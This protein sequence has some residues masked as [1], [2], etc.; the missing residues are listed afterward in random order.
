MN[1]GRRRSVRLVQGSSENADIG[2]VPHLRGRRWD[3][4]LW[5]GVAGAIAILTAIAVNEWQAAS[6][7]RSA[8]AWERHT[9]EVLRSTGSLETAVT[10]AVASERGYLLT[11]DARYESRFQGERTA[12]ADAERR[13]VALTADNRE[14]QQSLRSLHGLL[15]DYFGALGTDMAL[16][17]RGAASVH[18]YAI[19][20][21]RL[22]A[23]LQ[24]LA[25]SRA[26][27]RDLLDMRNARNNAASKRIETSGNLLL[28]LGA[29]LLV[30]A[31]AQARA[32]L[33]AVRA[34][35]A[36]MA[37]LRRTSTTDELTDLAN[38]RHFFARLGEE[39]ARAARQGAPLAVA[40]LDV[41]HFKQVNDSHGHA[42]GDAVLRE[43]ADR[44]RKVTR[45]GELVGR[46]GGE[47]FAILLPGA[48]ADQ[49]WRLCD[50][51]REAQSDAPIPLPSGE[52]IRS[53]L[54][55]GVAVAVS[56]E[57]IERLM[58]RADRALYQ[59]KRQGR[60]RDRLAA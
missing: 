10:R 41:D 11:G 33:R 40:I 50:R 26:A 57:T 8:A 30:I 16:R 29:L 17:E 22:A 31:A 46:I 21:S 14:R 20:D 43:T 38:R 2:G 24:A 58:A 35:D 56:G 15:E 23:V 44:L 27:E 4:L 7:R 13:L 54:S 42:A 34:K 53:T 49:A 48:A 1:A 18:P 51:L 12:A 37:E 32:T 47:E 45:A 60:D 25:A 19:S 3:V 39:L 28:A 59:A 6:T 9:I 36:L 55:G 5:L 52:E